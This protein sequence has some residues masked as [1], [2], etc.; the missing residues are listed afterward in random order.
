MIHSPT[1]PLRARDPVKHTDLEVIFDN[2]GGVTV[3]CAEYAH[4]YGAGC[5]DQAAEDFSRLMAGEDPFWW[6]EN[7]DEA[8]GYGGDVELSGVD[9]AVA[10]TRGTHDFGGRGVRAFFAALVVK[11]NAP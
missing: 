11:G 7:E 1:L 3:R 9:V 8:R 4:H 10:I 2:A 6:D 5:A